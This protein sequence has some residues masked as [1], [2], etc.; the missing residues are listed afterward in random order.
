MKS[1]KEEEKATLTY[2]NYWRTSREKQRTPDGTWNAWLILAGRGW[3]KTRTGAFD[4][5]NYAIQNKNVICA[6]VAPTAGDLRRVCFEGVSGIRQL[7]P[8]EL[9]KDKVGLKAYNKSTA[10]I[11]LWNGSKII[12][13]SASEPDRLRGSQYHRA[14]CDE[15]ASVSYTHLRAHET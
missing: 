3:G 4:I 12:G 7:I 10:Q 11:N 14:W 1:A 9:L 13:F 6:V 5:V 8:Q 15:L 2:I